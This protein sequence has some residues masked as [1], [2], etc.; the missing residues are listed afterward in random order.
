MVLHIDSLG[1]ADPIPIS[2]DA[3][4][5]VV[6]RVQPL[7]GQSCRYSV[8]SSDPEDEPEEEDVQMALVPSKVIQT[9]KGLY[10]LYNDVVLIF[11]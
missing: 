6:I 3:P 8:I 5:Y 9:S 2:M 4:P 11:S 1:D 7:S 10:N